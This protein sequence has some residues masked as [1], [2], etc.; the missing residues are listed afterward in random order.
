MIVKGFKQWMS[1]IICCGMTV[2]RMGMLAVSVW[3]MTALTANGQSTHIEDSVTLI[4]NS[5]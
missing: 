4:A 5:R 2:K 3:K 1:L